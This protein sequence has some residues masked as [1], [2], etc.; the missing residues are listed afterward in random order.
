M[1]YTGN[2]AGMGEGG[3]KTEGLVGKT[4]RKQIAGTPGRSVEDNI[5]MGLKSRSAWI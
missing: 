4:F 5:K 2:E 3:K 1:R